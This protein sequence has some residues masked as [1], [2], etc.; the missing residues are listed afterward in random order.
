MLSPEA[1]Q[2]LTALAKLPI[3]D[4]GFTDPARPIYVMNY[5]A[6]TVGDVQAARKALE[7]SKN[8]D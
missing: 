6:I 5:S 8:T 1:I 7:D 3:E 4:F 2:A